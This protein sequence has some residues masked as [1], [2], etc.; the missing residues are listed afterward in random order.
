MTRP[1]AKRGSDFIALLL[2]RVELVNLEECE[3]LYSVAPLNSITDD[4]DAY[5]ATIC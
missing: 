2:V 5:T 3:N 4:V 1:E